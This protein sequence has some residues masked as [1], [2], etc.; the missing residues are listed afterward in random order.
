M[1][2]LF[3]VLSQCRCCLLLLLF[4]LLTTISCC[5]FIIIMAPSLKQVSSHSPLNLACKAFIVITPKLLYLNLIAC[6]FEERNVTFFP[7]GQTGLL[8]YEPCNYASNIA[9]YQVSNHDENVY[10]MIMID[11]IIKKMA[12]FHNSQFKETKMS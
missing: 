7:V 1:S 10:L 4:V 9:Y 5:Y 3:L 8:V 12:L 11:G 2:R 6:R